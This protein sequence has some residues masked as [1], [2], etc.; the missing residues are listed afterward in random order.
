M[1]NPVQEMGYT[2]YKGMEGL[3]NDIPTVGLFT[4]PKDTLTYEGINPRFKGINRR[5]NKAFYD[6]VEGL[7]L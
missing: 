2:H 7:S 3:D 5:E 4:P 1:I 6:L